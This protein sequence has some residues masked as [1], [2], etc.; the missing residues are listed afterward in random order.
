MENG[1]VLNVPSELS[2]GETKTKPLSKKAARPKPISELTLYRRVAEHFI[3]E[4]F[5][6]NDESQTQTRKWIDRFSAGVYRLFKQTIATV[7]EEPPN[8]L[9][10][11]TGVFQD[12]DLTDLYAL[13]RELGVLGPDE[14][15]KPVAWLGERG[16]PSRIGGVA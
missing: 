6:E 7:G 5:E 12:M 8:H 4:H 2:R 11:R 1:N 14:R 13:A 15:V 10:R 9:L 3:A 16:D